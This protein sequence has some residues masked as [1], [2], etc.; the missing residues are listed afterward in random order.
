MNANELG[1]YKD[2]DFDVRKAYLVTNIKGKHHL[3]SLTD[4]WFGKCRYYQNVWNRNYS[5]MDCVNDEEE[6]CSLCREVRNSFEAYQVWRFLN[7]SLLIQ[8]SRAI[9][10][11]IFHKQNWNF[12]RPYVRIDEAELNDLKQTD[13]YCAGFTDP[14]I[15]TK[16]EYYDLFVDGIFSWK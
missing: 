5:F 10:L 16:E 1:T 2:S 8:T 9:P 14:S 7:L 15:R 6:S 3:Y 12:L 13:G 11:F 4:N